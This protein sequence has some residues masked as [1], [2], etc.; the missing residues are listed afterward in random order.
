MAICD[1]DKARM[2]TAD[3][4]GAGT[5]PSPYVCYAVGMGLAGPIKMSG[6]RGTLSVVANAPVSSV[7][8]TLL[9]LLA[10]L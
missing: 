9:C 6:G 3:N 8:L 10:Q 7:C 2:C 1:G 5:T 4:S